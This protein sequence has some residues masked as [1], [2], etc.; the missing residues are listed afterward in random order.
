[1]WNVY[2]PNPNQQHRQQRWRTLRIVWCAASASAAKYAR[3]P[4]D[5]QEVGVNSLQLTQPRS[6][7]VE[8]VG[9]H[10]LNQLGL[11]EKLSEL[12]LNG[13]MRAT[14][15]GNLIGRLAKPAFELSTW[16]RLHWNELAGSRRRAGGRASITP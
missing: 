11:V 12:G 16:H 4:S 14:I 8:H 9:L 7:G 2:S 3:S 1:M 15:I 13:A 5:Y 10:T 6:V